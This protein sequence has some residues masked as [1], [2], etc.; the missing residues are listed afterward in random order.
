[1]RAVVMAGGLGSR[2]GSLTEN[3]PKPMLPVAGKPILAIVLEQLRREGFR[4]VTITTGFRSEMIRDYCRDGSAWDLRIRYTVETEPLGTVGALSLVEGVP[5]GPVLVMN[6]DVLTTES[7][8]AVVEHH[9][10][11]QAAITV[12]IVRHA[13]EVPFGV[14]RRDG[15]ILAEIVEKPKV[16]VE[17]GAG[18]YVLSPAVLGLIQKGRRMDFPDLVRLA[19]GQGARVVCYPITGFWRDIGRIEEYLSVNENLGLL[20]QL[21]LVHTPAEGVAP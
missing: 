1:M 12:G 20:R 11:Q 18:I 9:A 13:Q 7:L 4:D 3:L 14:V 6:G 10:A 17:I 15:Q 8:R 19:Q 21:G 5:D 2:L 16:Y